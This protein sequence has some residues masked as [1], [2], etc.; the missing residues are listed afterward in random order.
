[1]P[2]NECHPRGW[3]SVGE[4]IPARQERNCITTWL[5][6]GNRGGESEQSATEIYSDTGMKTASQRKAT[7]VREATHRTATREHR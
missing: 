7:K 1:M 6:L 4:R 3:L 5:K 2:E